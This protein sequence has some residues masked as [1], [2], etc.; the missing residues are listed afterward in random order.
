MKKIILALLILFTPLNSFGGVY[1][2]TDDYIN[3][4]DVTTFD[5]LTTLSVSFWFTY[6]SANNGR[7][8]HKWGNAGTE[9]QFIVQM[10]QTDEILLAVEGG[11][12][13][14]ATDTDA[15]NLATNTWYHVLVVWEGTNNAS[16]YINGSLSADTPTSTGSVPSL[17]TGTS[18]FQI[19]YET[20]EA[21]AP[22]PMIITEV[23]I[24]SSALTA[25]DAVL[26]SSKVKR[27]PL[28]VSPSTLLFYEPLDSQP[29]GTSCD[30]DTFLDYKSGLTGTGND[31]ANNA[32]LTAKAEEVLSYPT[33]E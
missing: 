5:N 2:I 26:L 21:I 6:S 12:A 1:M 16:F 25:Q 17:S 7:I 29:D 30:G 32:N 19:G 31:G 28:Q 22:V 15:A 23:A 10:T 11:G 27:M 20:D 9:D 18:S 14:F 3:Y 4:G 24:W 33:N 13:F 8:I